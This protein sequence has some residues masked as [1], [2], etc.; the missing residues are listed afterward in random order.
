MNPRYTP[1]DFYQDL[2][3]GANEKELRENFDCR[4]EAFDKMAEKA[5]KDYPLMRDTFKKN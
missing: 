5:K 2:M 1:L 3:F 4:G